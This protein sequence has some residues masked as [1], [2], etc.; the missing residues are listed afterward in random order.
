MNC[1]ICFRF[2][3]IGSPTHRI[4]LLVTYRKATLSDSTY[5]TGFRQI[6]CTRIERGLETH[7]QQIQFYPHIHLFSQFSRTILSLS[8]LLLSC[9]AI[10]PFSFR[11]LVRQLNSRVT[12]RGSTLIFPSFHLLL[13]SSYLDAH[14]RSESSYRHQHIFRHEKHRLC[15][16]FFQRR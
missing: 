6:S 7:I 12:L 13:L 8:G 16:M 10:V 14:F 2:I 5:T 3:I 15:Y 9:R 11:L 1:R 4:N